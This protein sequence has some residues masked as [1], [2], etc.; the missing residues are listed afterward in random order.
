M[1][2]SVP[3]G[4]R[5][6]SLILLLTREGRVVKGKKNMH[7]DIGSGHTEHHHL[8]GKKMQGKSDFT[9]MKTYSYLQPVIY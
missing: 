3:A 4:K 7:W 1:Q 8:D 5:D 2:E 9:E 6:L